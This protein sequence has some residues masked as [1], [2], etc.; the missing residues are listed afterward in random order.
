MGV[1]G[2][3]FLEKLGLQMSITLYS[4]TLFSGHYIVETGNSKTDK[5]S[6]KDKK[7]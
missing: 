6:K 2:V 1:L 4:F 5:M 7:E 3:T